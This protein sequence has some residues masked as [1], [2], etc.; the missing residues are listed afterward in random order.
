MVNIKTRFSWDGFE[1]F[2][3]QIHEIANRI[4]QTDLAVRQ[5]YRSSIA[6]GMI[7][8]AMTNPNV[9]Q[10]QYVREAANAQNELFELH[11]KLVNEYHFGFDFVC[12][13]WAPILNPT[14]EEL[15]LCKKNVKIEMKEFKNK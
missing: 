15:A 14:P 8:E 5:L 6:T 11:A 3:Q 2:R 10:N 1:H 12:L 9:T 13:E 4:V 7:C